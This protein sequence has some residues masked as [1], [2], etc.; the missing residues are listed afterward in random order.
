VRAAEPGRASEL[1]GGDPAG[2]QMGA[3]THLPAETRA[4]TEAVSFGGV[5]ASW[6]PTRGILARAAP[7]CWPGQEPGE[8]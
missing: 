1:G 4:D 6:S 5:S 8:G 2:E 7:A 3:F